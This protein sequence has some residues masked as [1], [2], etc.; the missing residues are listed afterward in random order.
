[1]AKATSAITAQEPSPEATLAAQVP[2][3]AEASR[4]SAVDTLQTFPEALANK[5]S[6][7]RAAQFALA[8]HTVHGGLFQFYVGEQELYRLPL[9]SGLAPEEATAQAVALAHEKLSGWATVNA[10]DI[11]KSTDNGEG[12]Y[13]VVLKDATKYEV[14]F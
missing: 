2:P 4:A 1:M 14:K 5:I 13:T 10:N 8:R 11:L 6:A 12:S 7:H 3:A 9:A